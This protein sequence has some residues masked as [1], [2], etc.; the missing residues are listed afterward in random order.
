M[1]TKHLV[2]LFRSAPYDSLVAQEGLDA[3]F[4]AAAF[5]QRVSVLFMDEG[6]FQLCNNQQPQQ[7]KSMEKMLQALELYDVEQRF[8]HSH[9]LKLRGLHPQ[10]L[11]LE[12]AALDNGQTRTLIQNA[13]HVLSF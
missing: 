4:A 3:I 10:D 8:V 13:D 6:V 1:S 9:S 11:C 7:Q 12:V 2:Y 5:G